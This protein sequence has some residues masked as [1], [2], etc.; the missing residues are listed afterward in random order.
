MATIASSARNGAVHGPAQSRSPERLS[1]AERAARGAALRNATPRSA[2]GVWSA[3]DRARDPL[4]ILAADDADRLPELV[5]VRYE[6][7]SASPF[8]FYRGAAAVMAQDLAGSA[9]SGINVQLCGDAHLANFGIYASPER[10]L[11]FDINDFDETFPG[12]WEWDVKRLAASVELAGRA[13]GFNA[14]TRRTAVRDAAQAYVDAMRSFAAMKELELWYTRIEADMLA[15][16]I[17]DRVARGRTQKLMRQARSN[18]SLKGAA[19][20]TQVVDG[21]LQF[22][23]DP[24]L[25][26][27]V[28]VENDEEREILR[29]VYVGYRRS[30]QDQFRHLLER[31]TFVDAARK[32]VGVGSVGTRCYLIL[33]QGRD[34]TDVLLLQIKEAV[35]SSLA[36]ALPALR[37]HNNEGQRVVAGQRL[38]Q[39]ASD[40]FLGWFRSEV[41][42][43]F[44]VRQF[45]DMKGSVP[46]DALRPV[47][48]G[49]YATACARALADGHAR[50][51]DR[52]AIAGYLGK[53]EQ[54]SEAMAEFASAYADTSER[55]HAALVR[56][57]REP[58]GGRERRAA[59]QGQDP[60][61]Q[62]PGEGVPKPSTQRPSA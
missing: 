14:S 19:K 60:N 11:L 1:A 43:D 22:L 30:L 34:A 62:N 41:G 2:L 58:T 23:S 49:L 50:S 20:L 57:L 9:V 15:A 21:Q 59:K 45:R 42:R 3:P 38:L 10:A 26:V 56:S 28:P 8:A 12:P 4:A 44:Y 48:L 25:L 36:D 35:R 52:V 39:S 53:G 47:G 6:R 32:V 18:D 46:M 31:F 5:P 54:F 37:H 27:R 24:P 51:G 16:D 29:H 40:I 17:K 55:D 7:M 61:D 13:N 33:L